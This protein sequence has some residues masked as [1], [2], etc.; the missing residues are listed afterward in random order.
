MLFLL[1]GQEVFDEH[2][3]QLGFGHTLETGEL[4]P[5]AEA[6]VL[7]GVYRIGHVTANFQNNGLALIVGGGDRQHHG[8]GAG[9]AQVVVGE[10]RR[11]RF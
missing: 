6:A 2:T 10:D 4:D 5:V 1:V 8:K 9:G 11:A 7:V 3:L